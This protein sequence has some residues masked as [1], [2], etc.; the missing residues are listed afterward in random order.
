MLEVKNLTKMYGRGRKNKIPVVNDVSFSI[1]RGKTLGL[2]GKSGCGK[3]T[4]RV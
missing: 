4:V 2:A 3:S 1:D